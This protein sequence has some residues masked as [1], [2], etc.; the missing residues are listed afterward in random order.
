MWILYIG[1]STDCDITV[2]QFLLTLGWVSYRVTMCVCLSIPHVFLLSLSLALRSHDQ[3]LNLS[4]V[5]NLRTKFTSKTHV[6]N[7]RS[8]LMSKIEVQNQVK[9]KQITSKNDLKNVPS[10]FRYKI[11][12]QNLC[13]KYTYK[14]DVQNLLTYKIMYKIEVKTLWMLLSVHVKRVSVSC[15]WDC[16]YFAVHLYSKLHLNLG[17]RAVKDPPNK[18]KNAL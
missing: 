16:Y 15:M 12:V 11:F 18:P 1:Y 5:I 9:S 6:Q 7:W 8:K 13:T 3:F 17:G 10:K 4:L 2:T 14:I